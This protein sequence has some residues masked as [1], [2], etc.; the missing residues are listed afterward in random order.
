ML[1]KLRDKVRPFTEALGR[2]IGKAGITPNA[3][4][5][6][7]IIAAVL[8]PVPL[9]F[10]MVWVSFALLIAASILDMLDGAVAKATGKTSVKGAFLDSFGDRVADASFI[11][12]LM[13][14]GLPPEL[15]ILLLTTS[16]LI[17]Y[18]RA[19]G[20]SLSLKM[21]GVGI[22]ERGDRIILIAVIFLLLCTGH[23]DY[24]TYL[25]WAG[26]ILNTATI[27]HRVVYILSRG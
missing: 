17:S 27:I 11:F 19:R 16:F 15:T 22:M 1:T 5:A 10:G 25:G 4:T 20:E 23:S 21:E 18:A 7:G 6:A 26:V 13:I 24:A 2:A 3:L 12:S 8:T 14:L 9:F